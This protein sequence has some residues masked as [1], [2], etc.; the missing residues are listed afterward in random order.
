MS[1]GENHRGSPGN[2]GAR[3]QV[4]RSDR[5]RAQVGTR[6]E[7]RRKELFSVQEAAE[8][9]GLSMSTIRR[10]IH[11]GRLPAYRVAGERLLRIRRGDLEA[12]LSSVFGE[13]M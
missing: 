5:D 7:Q 11:D 1:K 13:G 2:A 9:L 8:F 3:P 4:D 12:L 10:Y 6:K